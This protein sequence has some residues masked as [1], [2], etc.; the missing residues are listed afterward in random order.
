MEEDIEHTV[1]EAFAF[2]E[3]DFLNMMFIVL[4]QLDK[5]LQ[6]EFLG[7]LIPLIEQK[8]ECKRVL[9][10]MELLEFF[11]KIYQY[12][13]DNLSEQSPDNDLDR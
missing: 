5:Q 9:S 1:K 3:A 4:V 2:I 13:R 7:A 6:V 11:L 12:H 8:S 10:K